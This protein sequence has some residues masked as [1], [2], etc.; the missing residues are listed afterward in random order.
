M[1]AVLLTFLPS[2]IGTYVA[3]VRQW[4]HDRQMAESLTG[5]TDLAKDTMDSSSCSE[6]TSLYAST[7]TADPDLNID[8]FPVASAVS[9]S[10]TTNSQ[11][12]QSQANTDTQSEF[13]ES[14]L[15][16]NLSDDSGVIV[17][18]PVHCRKTLRA[19][20]E[21]WHESQKEMK[22]ALEPPQKRKR[23]VILSAKYPK[24]QGMY[25]GDGI[26]SRRRILK[27]SLSFSLQQ[28]MYM[29]AHTLRASNSLKTSDF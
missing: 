22:E 24:L 26:I 8:L 21:V 6:N 4:L 7:I 19:Q 10:T 14:D 12:R 11:N 1:P 2:K 27:V 15:S 28:I 20:K 5:N 13:F 23:Q 29:H 3:V 25:V 9:S 18:E 16:S 17:N